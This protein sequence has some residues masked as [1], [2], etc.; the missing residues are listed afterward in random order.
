MQE[1]DFNIVYHKGSANTNA[2]A[3]SRCHGELSIAATL[4]DTG[5]A[6]IRSAQ[7]QDK[8]IAEIYEQLRMLPGK[9]SGNDW[10]VQPLRRY[11]QIWPQL[12]LVKGCVCR[13]YIL[14]KPYVRCYYSASDSF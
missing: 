2:D 4:L 6:D 1:F 13:R 3:L 11:K 5:Q 9:P 12:L 7:Q 8:H 10:K 14:S